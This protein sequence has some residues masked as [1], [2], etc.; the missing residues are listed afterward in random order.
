MDKNR[1]R[2][3]QK[4]SMVCLNQELLPSGD[5]PSVFILKADAIS[6]QQILIFF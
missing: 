3:E 6:E 5:Q 4:Y 1:E 2:R